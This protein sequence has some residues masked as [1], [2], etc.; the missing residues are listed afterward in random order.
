M[1]PPLL[2]TF[3]QC[4]GDRLRQLLIRDVIG[5]GRDDDLDPVCR[6]RPAPRPPPPFAGLP[7][8]LG[9]V[10][11]PQPARR[12]LPGRFGLFGDGSSIFVSS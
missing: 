6:E 3:L 9:Q 4:R 8:P 2:A 1:T 11:T 12:G 10:V 5:Q 7:G